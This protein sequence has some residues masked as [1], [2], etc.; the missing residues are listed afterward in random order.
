[1]WI[2]NDIYYKEDAENNSFLF[3]RRFFSIKGTIL[4]VLL[5]IIGY[6][7]HPAALLSIILCAVILM[8]YSIYKLFFYEELFIHKSEAKG[9]LVIH[10]PFKK[11]A[12]IFAIEQLIIK[13]KG[14]S[15]IQYYFEIKETPHYI[16][17][18]RKRSLK[19]MSEA[20]IHLGISIKNHT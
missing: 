15:D 17:I 14:G 12:Y 10:S 16:K 3:K 8:L 5:S 2:T 13:R 18:G 4:L 11:S 7:I 20:L 19:L 1:M 6:Y 9:T